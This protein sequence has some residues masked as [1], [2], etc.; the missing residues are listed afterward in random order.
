VSD[1]E[2][3]NNINGDMDKEIKDIKKMMDLHGKAIQD[4]KDG[5]ASIVGPYIKCKSS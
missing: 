2:S 5:Y 4:I 3:S 1:G